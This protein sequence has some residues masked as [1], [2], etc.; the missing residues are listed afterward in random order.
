MALLSIRERSASFSSLETAACFEASFE[1]GD[2]SRRALKRAERRAVAAESTGTTGVAAAECGSVEHETTCC[3][4]CAAAA[5]ECCICGCGCG[6]ME[7][8][9]AGGF[10]LE[11]VTG[12]RRL[13][14][15]PKLPTE[16]VS[17]S[18]RMNFGLLSS[19][20]A[21][22]SSASVELVT[23]AIDDTDSGRRGRGATGS[24]GFP[25]VLTDRPA[26][27]L[28]P[29]CGEAV[30]SSFGGGNCIFAE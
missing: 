14:P 20:G 26:F 7:L 28:S 3:G 1:P 25:A 16:I 6:T 10:G 2:G 15:Q 11:H 24:G 29:G 19:S 12:E 23:I 18:P 22:A 4:L 21:I 27:F 30:A 9:R 17:P 8:R 13:L 5:V